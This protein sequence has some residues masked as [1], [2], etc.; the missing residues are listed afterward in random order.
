MKTSIIDNVS[1]YDD[2]PYIPI[3]VEPDTLTYSSQFYAKHHIPS[4][5]LRPG[6]NTLANDMYIRYND[7]T[8]N[9][10]CYKAPIK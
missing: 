1:L 10:Y 2:S 5:Q 3:R 4:Y 9:L 7:N 8:L 6:N